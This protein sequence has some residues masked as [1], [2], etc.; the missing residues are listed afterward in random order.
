MNITLPLRK[1]E[2]QLGFLAAE[3]AR[4]R[5]EAA[6]SR[7]KTKPSSVLSDSGRDA[8]V[9]YLALTPALDE[10]ALLQPL[11]KPGSTRRPVTTP[12]ANNRG[13]SVPPRR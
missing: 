13:R 11:L 1:V 8:V 2:R 3:I 9:A 7:L 6:K 5:K 12:P 10:D 4:L